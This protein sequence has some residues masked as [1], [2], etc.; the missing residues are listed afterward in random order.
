MREREIPDSLVDVDSDECPEDEYLLRQTSF[1]VMS[2]CC[3]NWLFGPRKLVSDERKEAIVAEIV[4]NDD[5]FV[6]HEGSERGQK[7]CC[8]G[9]YE[10]YK[11][12]VASL[13]VAQML[14]DIYPGSLR[15]VM[16]VEVVETIVSTKQEGDL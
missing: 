11:S 4:R 16:P 12:A 1:R 15:F 13:R 2:E 7:I 9:F 3:A 14:R 10:R 6:C 5:F 8:R